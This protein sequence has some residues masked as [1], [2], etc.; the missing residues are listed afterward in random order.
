MGNPE[1]YSQSISVKRFYFLLFLILYLKI[2]LVLHCQAWL[3][4]LSSL[5]K[6]SVYLLNGNY[7]A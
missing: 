3:E 2:N 5:E 6:L 7:L 1:F 4:K